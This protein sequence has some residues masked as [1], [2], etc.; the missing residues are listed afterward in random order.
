MKTR[1]MRGMPFEVLSGAFSYA[2][3]NGGYDG[4]AQIIAARNASQKY[5]HCLKSLFDYPHIYWNQVPEAA[6]ADALTRQS[7]LAYTIETMEEFFTALMLGFV[8]QHGVCA[9]GRFSQLDADGVA[10]YGGSV[11]NHSVHSFGCKKINGVMCPLM[12]NTWSPSWGR[13]GNC[14]LQPRAVLLGD[15]FVHVNS[16]WR[17]Q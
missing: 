12:G 1:A 9:S 6:K 11:A 3:V 16:E 7:S 8:V 14:Y 10:G 13:G 5:G 17:P 15:A 4:G 2:L